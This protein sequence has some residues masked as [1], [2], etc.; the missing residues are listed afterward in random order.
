M[1]DRQSASFM[2]T[3]RTSF[4]RTETLSVFRPPSKCSDSAWKCNHQGQAKLLK[5]RLFWAQN[6][7]RLFVRYFWRQRW[8]LSSS[9]ARLF[10]KSP[11]QCLPMLALLLLASFR[12]F[13]SQSEIRMGPL[14]DTFEAHY[15][16][17]HRTQGQL[18]CQ[19]VWAVR[20][21]MVFAGG[22]GLLSLLVW[23]HRLIRRRSGYTFDDAL[24]GW[25][26]PL[27][28]LSP[29]APHFL[30]R[31]VLLR[32]LSGGTFRAG[33]QGRKRTHSHG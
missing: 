16:L 28:S 32:Q 19:Q 8:L 15:P 22:H 1:Q 33:V 3:S 18:F 27:W 20:K 23:R 9:T 13:S 7:F 2:G 25:M 21:T 12:N 26:E 6:L 11:G 29:L 10:R 17:A 4:Q 5:R 14:S 31:L 24:K 30:F